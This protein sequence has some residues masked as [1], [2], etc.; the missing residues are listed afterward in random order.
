MMTQQE[1]DELRAKV[2]PAPLATWPG[3]NRDVLRLL[4]HIAALQSENEQRARNAHDLG[5]EHTAV[6]RENAALQERIRALEAPWSAEYPAGAQ[7]RSSAWPIAHLVVTYDGTRT[8]V[9][10]DGKLAADI[11]P[12]GTGGRHLNATI[13]REASR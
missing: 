11:Q 1:L 9:Y 7:M 4:D 6:M 13:E 5:E 3:R 8:R 10:I 2:A 12:T